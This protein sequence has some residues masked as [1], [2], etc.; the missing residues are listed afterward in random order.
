MYN[1]TFENNL[2]QLIVEKDRIKNNLKAFFIG[3]DLCV[4]ILG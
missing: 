1:V 2:H 3:K 4:I